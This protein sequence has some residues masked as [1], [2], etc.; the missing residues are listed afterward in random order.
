MARADDLT[1][2]HV[3][4]LLDAMAERGYAASTIRPTLSLLKRVLTFGQRRGKGGEEASKR[5][6]R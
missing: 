4:A 5:R 3:E 6:C 1:V 2:E